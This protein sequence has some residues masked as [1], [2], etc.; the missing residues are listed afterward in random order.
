[1][2]GFFWLTTRILA[3]CTLSSHPMCW[4]KVM[5]K[6]LNLSHSC[7]REKEYMVKIPVISTCHLI[8]C[9][10]NWRK[11]RCLLLNFLKTKNYGT[12]EPTFRHFSWKN[13]YSFKYS[14]LIYTLFF[15]II[16][17]IF[18]RN[19]TWSVTWMPIFL[20]FWRLTSVW[21]TW[22]LYQII[23]I[24]FNQLVVS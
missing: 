17:K 7:H 10:Q 23:E 4:T 11:S 18:W 13:F 16:Q 22:I 21:R 19:L 5:L 12:M 3:R 15:I 24:I 14:L 2:K 20:N 9:C 1:M 8:W 6:S